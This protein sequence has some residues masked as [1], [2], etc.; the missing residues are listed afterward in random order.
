MSEE[1][2]DRLEVRLDTLATNLGTLTTK[3]DQM[4]GDIVD[5]T[6][7]VSSMNTYMTTELVTKEELA[8]ILTDFATMDALAE[9]EE[10]L[11]NKIEGVQRSVDRAYERHAA[12][13][14]QVLKL[15]L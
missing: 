15:G 10:S 3:V 13:V 2:F 8:E 5:L 11:G 7:I 9:M 6:K 12:L 14:S 4:S 1:R